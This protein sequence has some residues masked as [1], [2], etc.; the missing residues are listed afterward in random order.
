[1]SA[2]LPPG[3]L[4][5]YDNN[6][7][8]HY[9]VDTRTGQSQWTPPS[10]SVS[11]AAPK[12]GPPSYEE[13]VGSSV[14]AFTADSSRSTPARR[15][16]GV[17]DAREETSSSARVACPLCTQPVE[18][19]FMDPHLESGCNKVKFDAAVLNRQSSARQSHSRAPALPTRDQ[20]VPYGHPLYNQ[21]YGAGYGPQPYGPQPYGPG[22]SNGYG[23]QQPQGGSSRG[24]STGTAVAGGLMAG[25]LGGMLLENAFDGGF[26][27]GFF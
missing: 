23:P 1:M 13:S 14:V 2:S 24:M 17:I 19:R 9:Y 20:Q 4:Q 11:T 21:Q 27:G 3:W 25:L 18:I 12:D 16:A 10:L 7:R 5:L 22:H 15:A 6:S 8:K 26:G